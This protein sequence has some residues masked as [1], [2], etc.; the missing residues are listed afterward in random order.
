L[1]IALLVFL[2]AFGGLR[3]WCID[4]LLR[5]VVI[6]GPSMAPAFCGAHYDVRCGDC[7]FAFL[8]DAEHVPS[9]RKAVCA[10][11]GFTENWL[12]HAQLMPADHVLIDR[13][14]LLFR[15]PRRGEVV[16]LRSPMSD[17]DLA[18]KRV[19]AFPGERLRI[20]EG[21]LFAGEQIIRKSPAELRTVRM[22]VHDN[23]YQPQ[24]SKELLPRWRATGKNTR[25]KPLEIENWDG[26]RLHAGFRIDTLAERP[27][28]Y[29]W[30]EYEHRACTGNSRMR[31]VVSPIMDFDS[32]NQGEVHRPLNVV[33]D[34]SVAFRIRSTGEGRLA[35]KAIEGERVFKVEI[36]PG[37]R[38]KARLDNETLFMGT[39]PSNRFR[40]S[41]AHEIEFGFCDQQ[42]F[43]VVNEETVVC[44]AFDKANN[45]GG[46]PALKFA[47]GGTE[48]GILIDDLKV[49]RDIY[50]LD[51]SAL[52]RDWQAERPLAADEYALLGDNQP[53]SLDSRQWARAG[54]SRR[55]I[56]G[57]VY[58]RN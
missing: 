53:V 51:P 7:G 18:V 43:L 8:C 28:E 11:C 46:E 57:L 14:P 26:P 55:T 37:L 30:L 21:D 5:R 48:P 33:R 25:W 45:I 29:D 35:L 17:S 6:D 36:E 58:K 49:W 24:Q 1:A 41:Q 13:W 9:D 44:H 16:A 38:M 10:N 19:A 31:S 3:L 4:G 56:L 34:V 40:V 27:E 22:L 39:V 47:I 2:F 23:N 15:G 54:I 20:H 52:S 50:Y 32:F 12:A 42:A